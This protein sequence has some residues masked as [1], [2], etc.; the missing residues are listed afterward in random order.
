M[1]LQAQ[2]RILAFIFSLEEA[3]ENFKQISYMIQFILQESHCA[4]VWRKSRGGSRVDGNESRS[5]LQLSK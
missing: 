5:I 3:L 2:E 4:T 1:T